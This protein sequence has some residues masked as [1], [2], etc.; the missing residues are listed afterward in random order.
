MSNILARMHINS[1]QIHLHRNFIDWFEF[2]LN[3]ECKESFRSGKVHISSSIEVQE[4]DL[5]S[6]AV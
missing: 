3:M 5:I 6:H 4:L 2:V 1:F